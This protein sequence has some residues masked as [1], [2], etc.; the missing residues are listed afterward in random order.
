MHFKK[1]VL[2]EIKVGNLGGGEG[3]GAV[4]KEVEEGNLK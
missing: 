4:C 1:V 2:R 3:Q